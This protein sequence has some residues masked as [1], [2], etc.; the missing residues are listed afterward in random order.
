M[1]NKMRSIQGFTFLEMV[2]VLIIA[3]I[4]FTIGIP[5]F[6]TLIQGNRIVNAGSSIQQD[7]LF[8]RSQSV[9]LASYI[10][11]CPLSGNSCSNNWIN[12]LDIFIDSDQ[13]KT[14]DSDETL[15]K[16]KKAFNSSDTLAFPRS[17]VTF[18]PDGQISDSGATFRYCTEDER[19]GVQ[20]AFSGRAKIVDDSTFSNC[21]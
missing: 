9:S 16:S 11:V 6:T 8:A 2:I 7:L 4:I 12:G 15:L 13:D 19:V 10:T 5:A 17:S 21:L 3:S 14:L 18:T 20:L 1:D